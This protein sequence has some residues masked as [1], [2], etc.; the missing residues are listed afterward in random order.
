ML[1]DKLAEYAEILERRLAGSSNRTKAAG[2]LV[3]I[4][5][6]K[7]LLSS[8]EAFA[9]TLAVHVRNRRGRSSDEGS[10][11][12]GGGYEPDHLP[13]HA[14]SARPSSTTKAADDDLT[15]E[16]TVELDEVAVARATKAGAS[17]DDARAKGS[18]RR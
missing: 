8:I 4:A 1:A 11:E 14:E 13:R 9:R 15:E 5:L 18:S 12:G 3:T 6:Q 7:R 17:A 10:D 16:Q 2:K